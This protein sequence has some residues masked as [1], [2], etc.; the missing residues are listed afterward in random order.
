MNDDR[1]SE[2][3]YAWMHQALALARQAEAAGEVPIGAVLVKNDAAIAT[4]W[5][6][7]I[8]AHDPS[9]HAEIVALRAAGQALQN[10]RLVET[11]LYVTL[12]PCVM[13]MGAIV[14]ARVARLVFAAPDPQRG[15]AESVLRLGA[16]DFL[17][18][19]VA[20]QGGLLAQEAAEGLRAFFRR[21]RT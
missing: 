18:H 21:R 15:C 10:Y 17:N 9:A 19:R 2:A 14:H 8:L 13:C 11:T 4:G 7:P 3:D 20:C 1:F 16:A 5:N 12:E 6:Q